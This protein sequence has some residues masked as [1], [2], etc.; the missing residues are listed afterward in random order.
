MT[1]FDI[2]GVKWTFD[3]VNN[4]VTLRYSMT[5]TVITYIW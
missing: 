3:T 4:T 5:L 1:F 2:F